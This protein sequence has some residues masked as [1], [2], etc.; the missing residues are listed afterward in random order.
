[1]AEPAGQVLWLAWGVVAGVATGG[2]LCRRWFTAGVYRSIAQYLP[3]V[4]VLLAGLVVLW[5]GPPDAEA[6]V[7]ACGGLSS[8]V[9]SGAEPEGRGAAPAGHSTFPAWATVH[10]VADRETPCGTGMRGPSRQD[11]AVRPY[12]ETR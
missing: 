2:E 5:P 1:M 8:S 11:V 12:R 3:P 7:T 4:G 6:S 10:E 9:L